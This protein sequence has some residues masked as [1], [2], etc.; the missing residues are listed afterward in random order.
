MSVLVADPALDD[1]VGIAHRDGASQEPAVG[2]VVAAGAKLG[3]VRLPGADRRLERQERRCPVIRMDPL[4]PCLRAVLDVGGADIFDGALV[5]PI[6]ISIG[7]RRPK[8]V[9]H[10]PRHGGF[11]KPN[12]IAAAQ[13]RDAGHPIRKVEQVGGIEDADRRE[14]KRAIA[15]MKASGSR[16]RPPGEDRRPEHVERDAMHVRLHIDHAAGAKLGPALG[17]GVGHACH[18]GARRRRRS[19]G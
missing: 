12:G 4:E 1:V 19:A 10:D 13:L 8:L 14:K 9:R 3:F 6:H 17:E 5:D 7:P 11:E 2:A 15:V 16:S 18:G